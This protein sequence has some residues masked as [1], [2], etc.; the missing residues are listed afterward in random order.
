MLQNHATLSEINNYLKKE[1]SKI[2]PPG[3]TTALVKWI[4]DHCGYPS[5]RLLL[6]PQL[7]PGSETV[8]QIKEIVSDIHTHRPIQYILGEVQFFD[9][10]LRVDER[11]LIPRPETEEM[12]HAIVNDIKNP[13]YNIL[14]LGSGSGCIALALKKAFP[15]AG[16]TG[17]DISPGALELARINSENNQ[18]EVN[19]IQGDILD[20]ELK[21]THDK[22]DLV[23]SNPPYVRFSEKKMMERNVLDFEPHSA[24]FVDDDNPLLFYKAIV[25]LSAG[26][27]SPGAWIWLEINEKFGREVS[28]ILA[29]SGYS[30][31]AIQKD[32]HEKDRFIRARA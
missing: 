5:T 2:Y 3:E 18:L 31:I 29:Q 10:Y 1:V 7:Q 27:S 28:S 19:W 21:L 26:I 9:L 8:A 13:P 14:D 20:G 22:F 30:Q 6:D 17:L 11:A 25:S 12:V 24:L 16:V 4:L 23:V 15:E 32:I